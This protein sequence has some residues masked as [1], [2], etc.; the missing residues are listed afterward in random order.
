MRFALAALVG[1]AFAEKTLKFI[2]P[3]FPGHKEPAVPVQDK[4]TEPLQHLEDIPEQWIWND[5]N[6]TNYLTNMRNQHVPTYCGSCWAH[7]ATSVMSDRIKIMRNA[8][9]PDI[10]IAP[11]VL[12][13]CE[14]P[15]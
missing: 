13:E 7:A 4:I 12:I 3:N 14:L 8:A 10:N 11:Q 6:G 9:F 5:I 15:D 1:V 2:D